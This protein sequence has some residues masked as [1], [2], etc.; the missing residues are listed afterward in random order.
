MIKTVVYTVMIDTNLVPDKVEASHKVANTLT[1]A[2][3][4]E[5]TKWEGVAKV[6]AYEL[7]LAHE[8]YA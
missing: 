3:F 2:L 1:S 6:T 8:F 7:D 4:E 5:L